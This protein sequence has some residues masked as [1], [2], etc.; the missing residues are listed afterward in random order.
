MPFSS[1]NSLS[2]VSRGTRYSLATT[3]ECK[4]CKFWLLVAFVVVSYEIHN[5]R[6]CD[7]NAMRLFHVTVYAH[8]RWRRR[9]W[10]TTCAHI[11][12]TFSRNEMSW[13]ELWVKQLHTH[14]PNWIIC[15]RR[16]VF[17][18]CLL[19]MLTALQIFL[20][21]PLIL[22][23]ASFYWISC[24]HREQMR[25]NGH[26]MHTHTHTHARARVFSLERLVLKTA[27]RLFGKMCSKNVPLFHY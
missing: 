11:A 4:I 15:V 3:D 5:Q 21:P 19:Y 14:T 26:S 18:T 25:S 9:W 2:N 1:L 6:E 12:R 20:S 23:L 8:Q 22:L 24:S 13:D 10:C 27:A 7:S 17:G 16:R